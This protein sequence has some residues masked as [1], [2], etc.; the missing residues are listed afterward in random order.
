M[1]EGSGV[2]GGEGPPDGAGDRLCGGAEEVRMG[3]QRGAREERRGAA[4]L[5]SPR[6][7]VREGRG[8]EEQVRLFHQ[9]VEGK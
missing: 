8:A 9:A 7:H 4:L 6:P 5:S 2:R 3:R 1:R